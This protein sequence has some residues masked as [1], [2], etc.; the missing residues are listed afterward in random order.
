MK[1]VRVY[2]DKGDPYWKDGKEPQAKEIGATAA[3]GVPYV[4]NFVKEYEAHQD[5]YP[6]AE[7]NIKYCELKTGKSRDDCTIVKK[8]AGKR[9]V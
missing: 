5:K 7:D 4:G 1:Y 6:T 3:I 9:W 2:P 8:E